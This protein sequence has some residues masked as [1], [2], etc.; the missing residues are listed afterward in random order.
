MLVVFP[1]EYGKQQLRI[2]AAKVAFIVRGSAFSLD[3]S[4]HPTPNTCWR[5]PMADRSDRSS[6][7]RGTRRTSS[8]RKKNLRMLAGLVIVLLLA[9]TAWAVMKS[10]D[11]SVDKFGRPTRG[12]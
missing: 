1:N 10:P 2:A 3:T 5:A 12:Q 6:S 11:S 4:Q 8:R 7:K 9:L